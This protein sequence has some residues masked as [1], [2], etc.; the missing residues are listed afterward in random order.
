MTKKI[1]DVK[2]WL[3]V[4]KHQFQMIGDGMAK[5]LKD[6]VVFDNSTCLSYV[7]YRG[8]DCTIL[9]FMADY[10]HV[11]I[12]VQK[13]DGWFDDEIPINDVTPDSMRDLVDRKAFA[14]DLREAYHSID[15]EEELTKLLTHHINE[16]IEKEKNKPSETRI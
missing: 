6:G 1:K 9:E 15:A 13:R 3:T 11:K 5:R 14:S 10:V 8:Y 7:L 2:S 16:E 12:E 4:G